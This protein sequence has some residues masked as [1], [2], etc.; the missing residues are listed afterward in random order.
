MADRRV[1]TWN[2]VE[3]VQFLG[4]G[5][6]RTAH[7]QPHHQ[8]DALRAGFPHVLQVLQRGQ[9]V[10]ILDQ[11]VHERAVPRRVD[12]ARARSLQLVAHAAGAPDVHVEVLVELLHGPADRLAEHVAAVAG[13]RRVLHHVHG[14]R[15]DRGR[16]RLGLAVDERQRHGQAVVDL[17]P[18]HQRE[19]EL[20]EDEPLSQVGRQVGTALDDRHRPGPVPLVGRRELIGTAEREGG[21]QLRRERR[22]VVVIDQDDDVGDVLLRPGLRPLVPREQRLPVGLFGLAE[23]DRGPD[24]RD[25]TRSQ[26][27]CDASHSQLPSLIERQPSGERPPWIIICWYSSTGMPV[28]VLTACR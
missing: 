21:H 27:V 9:A 11:P 10:R 12:E 18:V 20:V 13:R 24:G 8:L 25:V 7:D 26:P 5:A 17:H 1:G 16:P 23:V 15:D 4:L 28:I 2:V 22:R 6:E 3:T 19:V 14:E